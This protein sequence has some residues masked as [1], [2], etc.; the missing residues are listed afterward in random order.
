VE[1]QDGRAG[2]V[3]FESVPCFVFAVDKKITLGRYI[4]A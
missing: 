4:Y 3:K 2:A 1:Y